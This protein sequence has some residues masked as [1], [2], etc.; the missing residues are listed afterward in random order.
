MPPV[1]GFFLCGRRITSFQQNG[2]ERLN[3]ST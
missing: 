2:F 3:F 1:R